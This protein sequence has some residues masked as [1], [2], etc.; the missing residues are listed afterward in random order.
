MHVDQR[1]TK[2][3]KKVGKEGEV[4]CWLAESSVTR[5]AR[6][7]YTRRQIYGVDKVSLSGH[8]PG[9]TGEGAV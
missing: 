4:S 9:E 8:W 5:L 3:E 7:N 6:F 2:E 1:R